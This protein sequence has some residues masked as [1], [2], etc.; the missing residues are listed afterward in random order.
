ML[1]RLAQPF[2]HALLRDEQDSDGGEGSGGGDT[3][4]PDA[5]AEIEK[6]TAGLKEKN[7]QLLD[8]RK[9]DQQALKQLQSQFE[10]LGGEE[11]LAQ[12]LKIKTNFEADENNKLLADG[13]YDE[14]RAKLTESMKRD[15]EKELAAR[16][17][18]IEEANQRA[19]AAERQL[20]QT[21][22][23]TEVNA[24]AAKSGV[25]PSA[26]EDIEL[27]AERNFV[28][29]SERQQL[30]LKDSE[31]GV[32]YGK[33][34]KPKSVAEWLED[35]KEVAKHWWPPSTSGGASGNRTPGR[36][37]GPDLEKM[38]PREFADYMDKQEKERRRV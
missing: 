27:R 36:S 32:V 10:K 21:L 7:R 15:H 34:G 30:V 25:E 17:S 2:G 14:Y 16:D 33:D 31:G 6:A 13:K 4:T 22:L 38:S 29:D 37:S 18:K 3:V 24:A 5:T 19:E 23:R 11:G 26:L 35:Q 20:H 9:K 1:I 12:L 8:E 28:F